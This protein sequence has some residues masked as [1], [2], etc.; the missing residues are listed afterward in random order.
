M[1]WKGGI[2]GM[3]GWSWWEWVYDGG[4]KEWVELVEGVKA[5]D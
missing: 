3:R 5:S 1:G 4:R 2:G